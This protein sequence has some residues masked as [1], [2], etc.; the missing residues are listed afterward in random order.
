MILLMYGY[1]M[2]LLVYGYIII[3]LVY[4]YVTMVTVVI[5]CT[6]FWR[7]LPPKKYE[8]FFINKGLHFGEKSGKLWI[9]IPC[10]EKPGNLN[11]VLKYQG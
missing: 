8:Y 4:G 6:I 3:L 11:S 10:R 5:L 9:Q 2:I 7:I 1:I